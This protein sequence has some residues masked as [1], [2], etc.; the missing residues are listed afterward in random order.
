MSTVNR[1]GS[2]PVYVFVKKKCNR[3]G[4]TIKFS[5]QKLDMNIPAGQHMNLKKS[6]WA[7]PQTAPP[8]FLVEFR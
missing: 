7:C 6:S 5:R 4:H 8:Q 2:R 1:Y 3:V